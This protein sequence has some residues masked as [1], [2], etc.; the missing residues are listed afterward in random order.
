M[1]PARAL[2][3][4]GLAH[5]ATLPVN[6]EHVLRAVLALAGAIFRKVAL[7]LGA[8]A[9]RTGVLRSTRLQVAALTGGTARVAVQHTGDRVAARIVAV[10]SQTTVAL[11]ARLDEPIAAYRAVEE[12]V[13]LVP[14]AIVHA[15]LEGQSQMLQ[16]ARG[17]VRWSGRSAG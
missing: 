11:F 7:V 13:R 12:P 14:Q 10:V 4:E 5:V 8:P 3:A 1:S 17:P 15:V 2:V 6:L 9:L 16:R